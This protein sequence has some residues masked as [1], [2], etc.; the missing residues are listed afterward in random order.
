ML[1]GLFGA[2]VLK[3]LKDLNKNG[4]FIAEIMNFD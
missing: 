1:V 4:N 2:V 3:V